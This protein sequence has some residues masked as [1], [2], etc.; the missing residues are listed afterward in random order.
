M[1]MSSS[2][3][4]AAAPRPRCKEWTR[5]QHLDSYH[6]WEHASLGNR[7]TLTPLFCTRCGESFDAFEARAQTHLELYLDAYLNE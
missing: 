7:A 1:S 5:N 4:P 2:P 6:V 3:V